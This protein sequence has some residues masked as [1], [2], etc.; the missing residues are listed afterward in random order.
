M[1]IENYSPRQ[2]DVAIIGAGWYGCEVAKAI[3]TEK[4]ESCV[5]IFEKCSEIFSGVS[6]TFGNRLHV[7]THYPRSAVTREFCHEGYREFYANYPEL[8]NEH[9]HSIYGLGI[10]DAGGNPSKVSKD[11]FAAVC[12]EFGD[13]KEL[14]IDSKYPNLL[15]A[16]DIK[17]PSL[18]MGDQ[19]RNFF[20]KKLKALGVQ[21]RCNI[22]IVSIK[23][24]DNKL[25]I[26]NSDGEKLTFDHVI[27]ATGFQALLPTV[28]LKFNIFYQA[29]FAL[30]YTQNIP[31]DKP[32]SFI[33]MDGKFP[34]LMPYDDR[35][36]KNSLVSKYVLT[37]AS[38]TLSEKCS[39]LKDA[40]KIFGQMAASIEDSLKN[41][42]EYEIK[43][44]YPN[45]EKEF[46]Y[47]T[48]MG[49]VLA[50][51]QTPEDFRGAITFKAGG[52]IYFIPGKISNVF[53]VSREVLS[54]INSEN[55]I[56]EANYS[57][58]KDGIFDRAKK[59]SFQQTFGT[60]VSFF[61]NNASNEVLPLPEVS[62]KSCL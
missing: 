37:H 44:F 11:E 57:Y 21:L 9:S 24:V 10:S 51:V 8:I 60:K 2:I 61:K 53:Q 7:G 26:E 49:V 43:R 18:V 42:C 34:S 33:V 16:A 59:S 20:K 35:I 58:V 55:I 46:T 19:L 17:E 31:S 38:I 12:R 30:V 32:F 28:H 22:T 14:P 52:V 1:K 25:V 48:Y 13:A 6:G 50:K 45:F 40:E 15:Y 39:T 3:K 41:K 36:D 23:S 56:K 4:P 27:N 29:C 62:P 47:L 5:T 54:F